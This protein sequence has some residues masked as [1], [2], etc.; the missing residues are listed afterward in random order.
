MSAQRVWDWLKA[1]YPLVDG[2]ISFPDMYEFA[3]RAWPRWELEQ[4][5]QDLNT[6]RKKLL[7]GAYRNVP[8]H[9][10]PKEL[11]GDDGDD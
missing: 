3:Q 1:D 2:T 8:E 7:G 10:R 4:W 5:A 9:L 11:R 6:S